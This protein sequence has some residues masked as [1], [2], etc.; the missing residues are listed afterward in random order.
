MVTRSLRVVELPV[1]NGSYWPF[2]RSRS[3]AIGLV[4][5][6]TLLSLYVRFTR[7]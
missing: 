7:S 4:A 5:T 3:R 2:R 1:A 6:K